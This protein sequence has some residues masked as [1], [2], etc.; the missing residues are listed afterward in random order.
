M[1]GMPNAGNP[2]GFFYAASDSMISDSTHFSGYRYAIG[3]A[4]NRDSTL[5]ITSE[6]WAPKHADSANFFILRYSVYHGPKD[7][8]STISNLTF[9]YFAN[10]NVPSDWATRNLA[11][12]DT[13]LAWAVRRSY[14]YQQGTSIGGATSNGN[15]FAALGGAFHQGYSPIGGFVVDNESFLYP[16]GALENDSLWNRLQ[17]IPALSPNA[18]GTYSVDESFAAPDGAAKDLSTILLF[19]RGATIRS[20]GRRDTLKM[21]VI[22]AATSDTGSKAEL[23]NTMA[24]AYKYVRV[25]RLRFCRCGDVDGNGA[26]SISDVVKLIN[27]IF[28]GGS[29]SNP[30]CRSDADSNGVITISDV[31]KLINYIFT[32]GTGPEKC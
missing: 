7:T 6:Y 12:W 3:Y 27:Y 1:D 25:N 5:G 22:V 2:Y 23:D 9:A 32:D 26:L 24:K 15:R 14:I 16:N 4:Y 18:G 11:G 8:G 13:T 20:A 29:A 28:L 17:A 31:V 21:T 10:F 30:L 19:Q